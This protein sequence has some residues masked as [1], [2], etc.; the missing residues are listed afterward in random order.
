MQ[1]SVLRYPGG[2]TR[3]LDRIIPILS[4][5]EHNEF[6]EVFVGGG[7]VFLNKKLQANTNNNIDNWINDKDSNISALWKVIKSNP[8]GL[9]DMIRENYPDVDLWEFWKN[10]KIKSLSRL[11]KAFRL[12]FLNRTNFSGIISAKPIGGIENQDTATYQIDCRWNSD[13]L[14]RRI[15][16]ISELL[17][18]V[19]ITTKNY[20]QVINAKGDQVLLF[21]DP[22]YY[23]KG[24]ML[25]DEYMTP[26][27]H[28]Y[29][30]KLLK[31]TEHKFLLTI[32]NCE[33]IRK[34]YSW[35]NIKN[36]EWKYTINSDKNK[37]GKELFI[38]NFD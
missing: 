11:E 27:Q 36:E 12:L 5:I 29:L 7:S 35:A 26:R 13:L 17:N 32:D 2:K 15:R 18:N 37:I 10:K 34:L 1:Y 24:E 9:I 31:E 4:D 19:R 8:E 38:T 25:Y 21:L 20:S 3:V 22:P 16:N 23:Q 28:K 30:A 33:K 14:I 6:R